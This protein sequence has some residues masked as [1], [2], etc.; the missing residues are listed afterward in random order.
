MERLLRG[1]SVR[2][3]TVDGVDAVFVNDPML[4]RSILVKDSGNYGK[5]E[6]FQ[7][8]RNISKAGMLAEDEVLHRHYRRL[9]NPYLRASKIGDYHATMRGIAQD[10]V[11]SWRPGH[12]VDIQTEM[13]RLAGAIALGTLFPGMPPGT[14]A[15]LT[16]RLAALNW[17]TIR[18]PLYGK[19]LSRA[20]GQG[21]SA[22]RLARA[23]AGV[24]ELLLTCIEDH[25]RSPDAE[26]G[27]LSSLL[28]DSEEKGG[29]SLT[30]DEVCDEA[31]MMLTAGTVTTASVMSWALYVLSE[32]PLIEKNLIEEQ[33]KAEDGSAGHGRERRPSGYTLRFLMEILRLYP[34]VWISC[35]KTRA[36]VTLGGHSIPE[37]AN[38]V[39][40]S[41]LLHRNPERYPE[42]HRFDPDRW[43]STRT[44]IADGAMYIPF[45]A[46]SKGC[47]GESFAWQELD[48]L[49]GTVLRTWRLSTEPGAQV[50]TAP[51]TT[52]HPRRLLMIPRP[53]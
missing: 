39:F 12:A 19:H 24:R 20:R 47:I 44:S 33:A 29:R 38:V 52:L 40:S 36:Q 46:G 13:C 3:L 15:D 37:G 51:E 22:H 16:E 11:A 6:L 9:A 50:R 41:Y 45:G 32:E 14:S 28:S 53:R 23:R 30:V 43:L 5:G 35:R 26:N 8:G 34:P 2:N 42:P 17:E 18:R 27:Y 4:V 25:L 21:T 1:H 48:I 31:V 49:L 10:A 7:K